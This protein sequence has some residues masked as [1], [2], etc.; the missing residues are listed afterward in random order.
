MPWYYK[1]F[2]NPDAFGAWVTRFVQRMAVKAVNLEVLI[3]RKY[4]LEA[5]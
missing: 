5:L 3:Y 2:L 1:V 4:N